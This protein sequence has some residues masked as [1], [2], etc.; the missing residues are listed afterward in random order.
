M[1][2]CTYLMLL[3]P[4]A[5]LYIFVW[6]KLPLAPLLSTLADMW[7]PCYL[8]P[9]FIS[10][11]APHG[12][13]RPPDCDLSRGRHADRPSPCRGPRSSMPKNKLRTAGTACTPARGAAAAAPVTVPPAVQA[14]Q[15]LLTQQ[16]Q[17]LP[18]QR[19]R[20]LPR[21]PPPTVPR[22]PGGRPRS[23]RRRRSPR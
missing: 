12:V 13:R 17:L 4:L 8:L 19:S 23:G 2:F 6:S 20:P 22:G 11:L 18:S 7:A 9:P 14:A 21:P 15:Q 1:P 10:S 5:G 3:S 16:V